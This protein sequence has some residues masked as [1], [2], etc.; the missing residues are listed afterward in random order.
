[1]KKRLLFVLRITFGGIMLLPAL[2]VCGICWVIWGKY[3]FYDYMDW[4]TKDL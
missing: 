2:I 4:C 1:M 3:S